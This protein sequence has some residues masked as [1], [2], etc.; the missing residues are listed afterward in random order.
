MISL[1]LVNTYDK[2][3]LHEIHYR[4][5]ARAIPI[6]YAYS[7]HL[8]L[9][10]FG[11]WNDEKELVKEIVEYTTI[12]DPKY[13]ESMLES[14]KIHLID[15]IPA[16][17]GSIVATTSRPEKGLSVEELKKLLKSES[18]TFLIG[19]G[20]KGLPKDLL[21]KS[22]YHLDITWKGVSLETCSAIGV[23]ASTIY[24]LMHG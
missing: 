24:W 11:F 12:G 2:L 9:L 22:K 1:C 20:R 18:L 23:I 14:G 7:F 6:C 16:H 5:I 19:L 13:A 4:S 10:D 15:K 8:A 21:K 17:F 3:K